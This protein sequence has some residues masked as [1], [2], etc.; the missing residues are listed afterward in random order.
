MKAI[1]EHG[2][3]GLW[4]LGMTVAIVFVPMVIFVAYYFQSKRQTGLLINRD[5]ILLAKKFEQ[6]NQDCTIIG[7]NHPKTVIDFLNVVRF[8][9]SEIGT[10]NLKHP[11]R[12]QGPYLPDNP[13]M[14]DKEY[15]IVRGSDG[16]YIIPG[17]GVTLPNKKTIGREIVTTDY[18]DINKLIEDGTLMFNEKPLAARINLD[19]IP[20][21]LPSEQEEAF[22]D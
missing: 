10:M 21:L 17:D 9:G 11:E 19:T 8:V 12:W 3:G 4:R 2:Q 1:V 5:V 18:I 22:E 6:I 15:Q 14:H 7:F 16:Y 13:T 20:L